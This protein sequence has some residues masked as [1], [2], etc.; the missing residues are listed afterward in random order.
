MSRVSIKDIASQAGV[1]YSTVSRALNDNPAIS[2]EVRF[3]IQELARAMGYSPNALAQGL[4][5]HRTH[6]IGLVITTIS[7]PFFVD[8]V[9]GVEEVAQASEYSTFLATSNNDPEREIKIIETFS[10]RRVDGVIVAA[11]QI[12]NQYTDRLEQVHIPV[13]M[14]NNQAVGEYKNLYSVSIDD[15]TGGQL[16]T[17]HLLGLGHRRIGYIGATNRPNSNARRMGGYLAALHEA[18][19]AP[20]KAWISN[21]DT[22]TQGDLEGDLNL[23]KS[24]AP[25]AIDCGV[26]ALFCYCDTVAVGAILALNRSGIP[27]PGQVSVIGFDD[28][29]LCE[30]VCPPLTTIGQPKR[31]MGQMAMRMLLDC[32]DGIPVDDQVVEPEVIVRSST[33]AVPPDGG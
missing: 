32:L 2:Q 30:I 1:S 4:I 33:S 21:Y 14:I 24:L 5:S 31:R 18:G 17:R 25:R 13:I 3:R 7:D 15:Y 28:N 27:V 16:A 8:V 29:D 12:S 11:S 6:S 22:S 23:W 9:R 20:E 26:T 19:I 10:R